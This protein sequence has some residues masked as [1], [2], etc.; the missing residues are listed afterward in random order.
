[1]KI[2]IIGS[3]IT[4]LGAAWLLN[5]HNIDFTVFEADDRI[6]GHANTVKVNDDVQVDT[7]FIVF[8][9]ITYPNLIALFKQEQVPYIKAD[10]SFGVSAKNGAL[11]YSSNSP[12]AQKKNLLSLSYWR[13]LIDLLRFYYKAP[14]DINKIDNNLTLGEYLKTNHYSVAFINY[15]IIP[16]AAAIWSMGAEDV[17]GFP[18]RSFLNFY[19]NHGLFKIINTTQWYTVEGGSIS[20]IE[21]ITATFKDRIRLNSP[22][23]SI[24]RKNGK[25]TINGDKFDK[26]II[27]THSDQALALLDD[28]TDREKSI[29]SDIKYSTN[30]AI[31][32][33]D[34]SQMPIN[35]MAWAAWNYLTGK[36]NKV[37][38][39]Y[40]MNRLQS[41]LPEDDNLFVTLNPKTEIDPNTIIKEQ[42]YHHPIYSKAAIKAQSEIKNIQGVDNIF[43]AGAWCG[44]GF[45]EDGLTAG[46]TA[47]EMACDIKRPW[48]VQEMSSA[49]GNMTD[50][51]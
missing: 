4:G 38:L 15:H 47:A 26:A 48:D 43:Y 36:G 20:Y 33:R 45:H 37:T 40:W 50:A 16:M 8:N 7:G 27:C 10:M 25:V 46:L 49:K 22:V 24:A 9:K 5:K 18:M 34:L 11:E 1:M 19:I 3:G 31:L 35:K 44:Y 32:H 6:G 29:L 14:R 30:I 21:R 17:F 28:A 13:M 12:F 2:A 23:K 51:D 42:I 41:F 39:T